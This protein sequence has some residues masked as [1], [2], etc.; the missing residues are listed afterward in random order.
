MPQKASTGCMHVFVP[1]HTHSK[2][3]FV[4]SSSKG[5]RKDVVNQCL[6]PAP[7]LNTIIS[8]APRVSIV[9]ELGESR[10]VRPGVSVLTNLMVF[11][12]V[13]QY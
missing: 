1:K 4:D 9:Q 6:D 13:K 2:P 12:D 3:R 7:K 8:H 5:R 11:V 10:G